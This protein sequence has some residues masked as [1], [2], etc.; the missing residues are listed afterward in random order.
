V[1][2]IHCGAKLRDNAKFCHQCGASQ[3]PV[4]RGPV[5]PGDF[6][7]GGRYRITRSL[8]RGGMGAVY[9]A[10]DTRLVRTCVVKEMLPDYTSPDERH[11]AETDFQREA[12]TLALLNQPGH[13][14]IPEIYDY[15]IENGRHYLVMKYI[16][17]ENLEERLKRIGR[18]LPEPDVIEWAIQTCDALAYMHSRQPEPVVHRDIKPAN[19][20]LDEDDRLWLVDFG[21]VRAMPSSRPGDNSNNGGKTVAIGTPGYTPPEQWLQEPEPRSDIYAL[22]ASLHHLLSGKD[23]R[24]A[25]ANEGVLTPAMVLG[26][27]PFPSVRRFNRSVSPAMERIIQAALEPEVYQRP[28]AAE[29]RS[30]LE[31][32][33]RRPG[34]QPFTFKS[35]DIA[36]S[37]KALVQV[38][39]TRWNTGKHH[40]L[41]GDLEHWLKT[42]G[43]YDLASKVEALRSSVDDEDLKLELVLQLLDSDLPLPVLRTSHSHL[44]LH[45][46]GIGRWGE[47]LLLFNRQRGYRGGK[48]VPDVSWLDLSSETFRLVGKGARQAIDLSVDYRRIPFGRRHEGELEIHPSQGQRKTITFALEMSTMDFIAQIV[49]VVVI[50][51]ARLCRNIRIVHEKVRRPLIFHLLLIAFGAFLGFIALQ[52]MGLTVAGLVSGPIVLY[53]I[54]LGG[55]W[56]R[57]VLLAARG[58]GKDSHSGP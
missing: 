3:L 41:R 42:I 57:S 36:N 17:G 58:L 7:Q 16:G 49:R 26:A 27:A 4:A 10:D 38:C 23:P 21:L 8:G 51:T 44:Q 5:R 25:F 53:G 47:T 43:R 55:F 56:F 31:A 19:L 30:E 54:L 34:T 15:F 14:N 48:L 22:G 33:A 2:C 18:P 52:E 12:R 50:G 37:T 40:L 24:D 29:L 6:F 45:K 28:T 11:K 20:I 39:D 32:I 13:P 1:W 35:G 9:Q 46:T